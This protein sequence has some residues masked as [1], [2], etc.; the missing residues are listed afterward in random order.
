VA[1]KPFKI[2][3]MKNKALMG[4]SLLLMA[5]MITS[6]GKSKSVEETTAASTAKPTNENKVI[7]IGSS[8]DKGPHA[9]QNGLLSRGSGTVVYYSY[10][11]DNSVIYQMTLVSNTSGDVTMTRTVTSASSTTDTVN[12][13]ESGVTYTASTTGIQIVPGSTEKYYYIPFKPGKDPYLMD[14]SEGTEVMIS[15][16]CSAINCGLY[17]FFDDVLDIYIYY[18]YGSV[19]GPCKFQITSTIPGNTGTAFTA[20]AGGFMVIEASSLTE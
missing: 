10:D 4:L 2:N 15:C 19:C 1:V 12:G 8:K 18:C 13:I 5:G 6:C 17:G 20:P 11:A 16:A 3:H 9:A 14:G 7:H